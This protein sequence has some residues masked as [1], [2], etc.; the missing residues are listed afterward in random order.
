[1]RLPER[2]LPPLVVSM[3][4]PMR[5]RCGIADYSRRLAGA[6]RELPDIASVNTVSTP[7]GAARIGSLAALKNFVSDERRYR[8][9]GQQLNSVDV[10]HIQHQYFFFGGVAPHKNHFTTLLKAVRV[11]LVLTVHEIAEGGTVGWKRALIELTN[12][13]NFLHP[14]IQQIIVH[15]QADAQK[16]LGLGVG[17][18]RLTVL[19]VAVPPALPLPS[20]GDAQQALGI[21]GKRVLLMFGFLAAKKG[22]TLA[23]EA[24]RDL[25]D[26]VVLIFAGEQ[27][28]DDASGYVARLKE[29]ITLQGLEKRALITG[30]LSDERVP[31]VMAA[32]DVALAPF[33]ESSGSA[34]LAHLLAYG[35]P[36]LASD[37]PPHRE[38]LTQSPGSMSL[39]PDGDTG[40]MSRQILELLDDAAL[41]AS[42]QTGAVRF[43]VE[44]SFARIAALTLDVYR[45]AV[46]E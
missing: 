10:A 12:R 13:R 6:L 27:H 36:V 40:A 28:P 45:K 7:E 1:M 46:R 35:L 25:P 19:P 15:T 11:P 16:L 38:L 44:R 34:S 21:S 41:R 31:L 42:L 2:P 3:L 26:D 24:L 8:S 20:R 30:Y 29:S 5:E 17:D 4:A 33:T 22:H 37:I 14:A 43:C 18:T 23:L 9:L 32:A 39:F